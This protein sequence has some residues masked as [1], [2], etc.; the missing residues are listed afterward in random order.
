MTAQ[1]L[2][3]AFCFA[4]FIHLLIILVPFIDENPL[5]PQLAG[6]N[7]IQI[8]LASTSIIDPV[9]EIPK[10]EQDESEKESPPEQKDEEKEIKKEEKSAEEDVP[11]LPKTKTAT[12]SLQDSRKEISSNTSHNQPAHKNSTAQSTVAVQVTSKATPLYYRNPKPAYPTLARKRNLQGSVILS[13]TVLANGAV[14]NVTVHK[15]SG[16]EILDN[17]AL[18][19][20]LTWHFL[21][22]TQNGRPVSMEVQVPIHFKLD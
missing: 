16:H 19:T 20:V 21:P 9:A 1:R 15:S 2:L 5:S 4:L 3:I 12:N 18:K 13:I 14:G 11:I 6:N 7:S 10:I 22:G 8:N 17:S